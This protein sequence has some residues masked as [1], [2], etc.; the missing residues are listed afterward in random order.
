M[1]WSIQLRHC[2]QHSLSRSYSR[3]KL[4]HESKPIT[5]IRVNLESTLP[6]CHHDPI[7][8][9]SEVVLLNSLN[10]GFR[11][12]EVSL[13]CTCLRTPYNK[14][15]CTPETWL[16]SETCKSA[17]RTKALRTPYSA[18]IRQ[19]G[20]AVMQPALA[21]A[22]VGLEFRSTCEERLSIA[23]AFG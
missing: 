9:G 21:L 14:K 6:D 10:V 13:Q 19:G 22:F 12:A 5:G 4:R 15:Y 20:G 18:R 7:E 23:V 17:F 8:F 2:C 16:I 1:S 11:K 3:Y